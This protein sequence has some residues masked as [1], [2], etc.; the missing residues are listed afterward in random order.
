MVKTIPVLTI[1]Q[2]KYRIEKGIY[3]YD[4]IFVMKFKIYHWIYSI[5]EIS[6]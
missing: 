6:L 2:L 5:Y 3:K 1:Y 4:A